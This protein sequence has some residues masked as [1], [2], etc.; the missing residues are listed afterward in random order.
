MTR[1]YTFTAT[2]VL[3]LSTMA[4]SPPAQPK[5]AIAHAEHEIP[6]TAG[7]PVRSVVFELDPAAVHAHVI[8]T[9][10]LKPEAQRSGSGLSI[11]DAAKHPEVQSLARKE[12][13]LV[14]G[15][16]SGS[17]TSRPV[18]LLISNGQ[19]ISVPKYVLDKG[20]P[21]SNCPALRKDHYAYDGIVCGLSGGELRI[22]ALTHVNVEECREAVQTGPVL[23]ESVG[24]IPY[25]GAPDYKSWARTALCSLPGRV[26]VIVTLDPIS[27]RDLATWLA[28]PEAKGGLG[29][30]SAVN[31]PTYGSAVAIYFPGHGGQQSEFGAGLMPQASLIMFVV[32]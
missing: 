3:A 24:Q 16:Y 27:M 17:Q 20:E 29:C 22:D 19:I 4:S 28:R 23:V 18:G 10:L 14:N 21:K 6:Q 25:C 11:Q 26:K 7:S 2:V 5:N 31:L 15:G 32:K 30:T 1:G 13:L 12:A 8:S 9:A